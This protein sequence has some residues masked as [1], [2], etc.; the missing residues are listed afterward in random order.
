MIPSIQINGKDVSWANLKKF[1]PSTPFEETT[2]E[3]IKKWQSGVEDFEIHTS[4][5]TGKPKVINI[6]RSKMEASAR[7][8]TE[9]L[10]LKSGQTALICL[11]TEY[12]AGKMMLVRALVNKMNI[13]AVTPAAN[14]LKGLN[15]APDFTALVPLQLE[16]ILKDNTSTELLNKMQS[17]I[18]GGAAI[19]PNLETKIKSLK[20]PVYATYGMTETVSHIAL[21]KVNGD[22]R[23]DYFTAFEEVKLGRDSRRCLTIQSVLT[24]NEVLVTNDSVN[25]LD[26]HCFEWLGRADNTINTGGVKV[27]S[28]EVEKAVA[29]IFAELKIPN[30]FFVAGL[31]DEKLG[32]KVCLIIET[33]EQPL[34]GN[35]DI[36]KV[37]Q[38]KLSKYE[39]PK[40]II[41]VDRFIETPTGKVNRKETLQVSLEQF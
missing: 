18:I 40:I 13:I 19:G 16:E 3:F 7:F 39:I 1:V 28:E 35:P 22:D 15:S 23:S 38:Q 9:A 21:K 26:S 41:Y 24:N 33:A 27:Q 11:D 10:S 6:K 20:V 4:G 29:L 37:L 25:L 2:I 17:V 34:V 30:R 5:S 14:P 32:E 36:L 12:I 31:P 8:T